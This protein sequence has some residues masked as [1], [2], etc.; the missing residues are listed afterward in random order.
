MNI[1]IFREENIPLFTALN[2]LAQEFSTVSGSMSVVIDGKE[3][4]LPQAAKLLQLNDRNKRKLA[5]K[6][7]IQIL[8]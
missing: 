2:N 6:I 8:L 1:S 3:M 4:T 5:M 7:T